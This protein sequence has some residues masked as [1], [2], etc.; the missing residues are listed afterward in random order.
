MLLCD[1]MA[2]AAKALIMAVAAAPFDVVR[3]VVMTLMSIDKVV[4]TVAKVFVSVMAI[5]KV[6]II[7]GVRL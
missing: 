4:A 1:A 5:A 3:A 6:S 2:L 7:T